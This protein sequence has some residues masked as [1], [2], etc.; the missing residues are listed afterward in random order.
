[1]H[2]AARALALS[3]KSAERPDPY[4]PEEFAAIAEAKT[5]AEQQT[6]ARKARAA[7]PVHVAAFEIE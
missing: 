6:K 4:L 1:M 2:P 7:R 3:W 5:E